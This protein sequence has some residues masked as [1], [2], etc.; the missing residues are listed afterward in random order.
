MQVLA[1][2]FMHRIQQNS[3]TA[4]ETIIRKPSSAAERFGLWQ[5]I[6]AMIMRASE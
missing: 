5:N 1:Q 4:L 6:A 2:H 3:F